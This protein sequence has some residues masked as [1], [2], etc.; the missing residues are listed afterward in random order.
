MFRRL[1]AF[2]AATLLWMPG[3]LPGTVGEAAGAAAQRGPRLEV[4][5]ESWDFGRAGPGELLVH[6]F[7]L[8]NTG[9]RVL[10]IGRI[11]SACACAAT[12]LERSEVPAG[13]TA[14]L[15]VTLDTRGYRGVLERWLTVSSNDRRGTR[16]VLVRVYVEA[17]G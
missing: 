7:E 11:A 8:R 3:S 17:G 10:S 1:L 15:R 9:N 12:V 16:R 5:P 14:I 6:D 2:A 13:G 4:E